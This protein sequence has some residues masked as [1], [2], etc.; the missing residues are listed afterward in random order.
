MKK[1]FILITGLLLFT[2]NINAQSNISGTVLAVA[3]YVGIYLGS[4]SG[5]SSSLWTKPADLSRFRGRTNTNLTY[6][7]GK[8]TYSNSNFS[9]T[10][11]KA[12]ESAY[13][14]GLSDDSFPKIVS[15]KRKMYVINKNGLITPF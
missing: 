12:I 4:G 5:G 9:K 11:K 7:N 14:S 10:D 15:I 6:S 8:F 3:E 1:I 13:K 2:V